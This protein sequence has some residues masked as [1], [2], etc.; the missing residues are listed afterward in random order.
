MSSLAVY[1][2][3]WHDYPSGT[4]VLTLNDLVAFI[5]VS[6]VVLLVNVAGESLW[7]LIRHTITLRFEPHYATLPSSHTGLYDHILRPKEP[8]LRS[9]FQLLYLGR[10]R[11]G[12]YK[13]PWYWLLTFVA[14]ALGMGIPG[15]SIASS[16]FLTAG[17]L[18]IPQVIAND[19]SGLQHLWI[20]NAS[21]EAA[22]QRDANLN[23]NMTF[24]ADAYYSS[25]YEKQF[26]TQ[27][28]SSFTAQ[29]LPY[30]VTHGIDEC[31]FSGGVCAQNA[32]NDLYKPFRIETPWL[33]MN[34]IGINTRYNLHVKK[35]MECAPISASKFCTNCDSD[36]NFTGATYFN[37]IFGDPSIYTYEFFVNS[38]DTKGYRIF[39]TQSVPGETSMDQRLQ[40]TDGTTT[41]MW[42]NAIGINYIEPIADP[43][44]RAD[45]E[46]E[47]LNSTFWQAHYWV[48]A[49]GC[50]DQMRMSNNRTGSFTPW[51]PPETVM[52]YDIYTEDEERSIGLMIGWAALKLSTNNIVSG[53]G[54]SA[55]RATRSLNGLTQTIM[56]PNQTQIEASAWF[57]TSLAKLQLSILSIGRGDSNFNSTGF[58]DALAEPSGKVSKNMGS[59]VKF[60]DGNYSI[61]KAWGIV[62]LSITALL[63]WIASFAIEIGWPLQAGLHPITQTAPA[64]PQPLIIAQA[65]P[66]Q[67][68]SGL[69][70]Q[71]AGGAA[72]GAVPTSVQPPHGQALSTGAIYAPQQ[73]VAGTFNTPIYRP[74]ASPPGR[75]SPY[76]NTALSTNQSST[77]SV[78]SQIP[79]NTL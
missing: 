12:L 48:T 5:V 38:S 46:V 62:A 50:V 58:I 70:G 64:S 37:F 71:I 63:L 69:T 16:Y 10:P 19:G 28:T 39:S 78:S 14:F 23:L 77:S 43:I 51:L 22:Y 44:F 57:G 36:A 45:E 76:S 34:D 56:A 60:V 61:I 3:F 65:Q 35:A 75:L 59:L 32:T 55:L 17:T 52:Q 2:G 41:V 47:F 33:S 72:P 73:P 49:L 21:D 27:C 53:R 4:W 9:F 20:A 8:A 13:H 29:S 24:A 11:R 18:E 66:S 40:R 7:T 42:V 79:L 1:V 67:L 74:V 54:S 15:I 6:V 26:A 30:T 31:P 68:S 25:C